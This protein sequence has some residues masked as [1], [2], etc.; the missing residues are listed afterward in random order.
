MKY[1]FS[2]GFFASTLGYHRVVRKGKG[3]YVKKIDR[4]RESVLDGE[5]FR[6]EYKEVCKRLTTRKEV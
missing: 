4:K 5:A 1:P 3:V 6:E 2:F